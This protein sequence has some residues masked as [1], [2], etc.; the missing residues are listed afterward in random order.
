MLQPLVP[1]QAYDPCLLVSGNN[2]REEMFEIPMKGLF[3]KSPEHLEQM[4][5]CRSDSRPSTVRDTRDSVSCLRQYIS[6][7]AQEPALLL[8]R[9]GMKLWSVPDPN[10][11]PAL[12]WKP[13]LCSSKRVSLLGV[14]HSGGAQQTSVLSQTAR[15]SVW[16]QYKRTRYIPLLTETISCSVLHLCW[17]H[18]SC[19]VN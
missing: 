2:S 3:G 4:V 10:L 8:E 11:G 18:P 13:L 7:G 19:K 17:G 12:G 5:I 6:S 1:Q 9:P 14:E 15:G 16:L